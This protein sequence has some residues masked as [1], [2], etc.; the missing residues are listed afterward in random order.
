MYRGISMDRHYNNPGR[1]QPLQPSIQKMEV[2]SI[3]LQ[4]PISLI[5]SDSQCL[6]LVMGVYRQQSTDLS[7]IA[8]YSCKSMLSPGSSSFFM[9]CLNTIG[10]NIACCTLFLADR[11]SRTFRCCALGLGSC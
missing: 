7:F 6:M 5:A 9:G 4:Q 8:L 11:F 10:H 3:S 2:S 1:Y